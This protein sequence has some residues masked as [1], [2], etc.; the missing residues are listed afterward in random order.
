MPQDAIRLLRHPVSH[1]VD[2]SVDRPSTIPSPAQVRATADA[3]RKSWTPRQRRQR[4]QL[5]RS[6]TLA[7]LL[8]LTGENGGANPRS[9]APR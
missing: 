8:C 1:D 6:M 7:Q 9:R 4:A 2:E 3:I 5:A